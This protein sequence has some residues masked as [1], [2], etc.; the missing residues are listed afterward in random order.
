MSAPV[1]TISVETIDGQPTLSF[2]RLRAPTASGPVD[3]K[4][5]YAFDKD[6]FTREEIARELQRVLRIT[7]PEITIK[8]AAQRQPKE[9]PP[10]LLPADTEESDDG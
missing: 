7:V 10:R 4:C 1:L 9:E 2:S 3:V 5:Y 8:V 6:T